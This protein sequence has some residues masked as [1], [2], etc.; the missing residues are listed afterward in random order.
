[1][2]KELQKTTIVQTLIHSVRGV[3]VMLDKD[4]A[5]LYGTETRILKQS[6]NRNFDRFPSE[7]C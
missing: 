5:K 7:S 3:H 6:V 4:L 2:A 1:M